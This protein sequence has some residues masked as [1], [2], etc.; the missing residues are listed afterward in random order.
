MITITREGERLTIALPHSKGDPNVAC[1]TKAAKIRCT[2]EGALDLCRQIARALGR[3]DI[4]NL[5]HKENA[6]G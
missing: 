1:G 4:V 5:C 3:E 2:P 6:D